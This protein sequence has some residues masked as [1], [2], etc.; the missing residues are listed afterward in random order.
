MG[1]TGE[2]KRVQWPVKQPLPPPPPPPHLTMAMRMLSPPHPPTPTPPLLP[3]M[4]SQP[5]PPM[6]RRRQPPMRQ[7]P[8]MKQPP[9]MRLQRRHTRHP[10]RHPTKSH[11]A[12]L[13]PRIVTLARLLRLPAVWVVGKVMP[14]TMIW[15]TSWRR[16]TT[17]ASSTIRSR[18]EGILKNI[19]QIYD[20]PI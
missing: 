12:T 8:R 4:N 9:H 16:R 15:S 18:R 13:N 2:L 10:Q 3:P 20:K 19:R 1:S 11:Q 14:L 17:Q 7:Q 5:P 6:W